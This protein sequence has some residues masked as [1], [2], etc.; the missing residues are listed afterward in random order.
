VL[1][2]AHTGAGTLATARE[3]PALAG[4]LAGRVVTPDTVAG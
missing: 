4:E 2:E 1:A 3:Q